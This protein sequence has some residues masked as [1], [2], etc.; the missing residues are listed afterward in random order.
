MRVGS[1]I[2]ASP[3]LTWKWVRFASTVAS[4][5]VLTLG[6]AEAGPGQE[7]HPARD[8]ATLGGP[9]TSPANALRQLDRA[10]KELTAKVSP[11]VVQVLVAGYGPV[12]TGPPGQAAVV[13]RQQRLGSGV[14]LDPSGYIMTNGHVI[15]GAQ[16]VQV[17]LTTPDWK[18]GATPPVTA[19]Q[20]VLPATV[21]GFTDYFDLALLKVEATDLPTLR[22]ADFR[23][24]SQ[25][26]VVIAVGSPLGLDNSV[27]M[28]VIS[29]TARQVKPDSTV[30]FV[31]TD[32]PINPGN[33]G[34]ALVDLDGRLVGINTL[35]LS[36]A[37]GSE[38]LGFALPASIVSMAYESLRTK[39]Y[40]DRR[41]IGAAVQTISPVLAKGL[42]LSR[43][44]GLVVCDLEPGGPAEAAGLKIGDVVVEADARSIATP[45][46]FEGAIYLHDLAGPL[47][48]SVLRGGS[49]LALDVNVLER[50]HRTD[51]VANPIDPEAN[52]VRRLGIIAAT[53]TPDLQSR[54]G[55]LLRI[56]WGVVVVART[57]DVGIELAPGDVIHSVNAAAVTSV[58]KLR[59]LLETFEPGDAVVLQIER[60]GG[61]EFV[62][63]EMD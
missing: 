42:G 5:A 49:I 33:S 47:K 15:K 13:I 12:D 17:I 45:A 44:Y 2:D 23:T 1:W 7:R 61:L 19:R 37:G 4:C 28:G 39:G 3:Q 9:G 16:R 43:G 24:V 52:L 38:G 35:I 57:S 27:T 20:A 56:P 26:Q 32:A 60:S 31:Q 53:V 14:I 6:V 40:V 21:V 55:R 29:S 8:E 22:F 62:S 51:S 30:V 46:Q 58:E 50:T 34:G 48:L 18:V 54:L 25:G 36:Q 63:F 41:V 11:A 10:L 59:T